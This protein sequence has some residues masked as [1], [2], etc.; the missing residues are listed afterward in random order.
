LLGKLRDIVSTEMIIGHPIEAAGT[1]VIP[2]T[3][4][5]LGFG[6]GSGELGKEAKGEHPNSATGGG[7]I[8]E[9]IAIITVNEKEIRVHS[10]KE[11]GPN[12][13]KIVD[14]IPDLIQK[15]SKSGDDSK[16]PKAEK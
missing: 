9:P 15:F 2:V 14:M 16:R 1:T 11:K 4:I 3:K 8:I 6:A 10:L 13:M 5:S 12:Y 7:A